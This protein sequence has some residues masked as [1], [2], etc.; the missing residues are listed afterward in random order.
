M[1]RFLV[2]EGNYQRMSNQQCSD[3]P[4]WKHTS[5]Y[6]YIFLMNTT[7]RPFWSIGSPV[8]DG[9]GSIVAWDDPTDSP[10]LVRGV[11]EEYDGDGWVMSPH[12]QVI[13]KGKYAISCFLRQYTDSG[14]IGG[15]LNLFVNKISYIII[16]FKF[17]L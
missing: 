15:L 7:T 8:C 11:W 6:Q 1:S 17:S 13:C 12:L 10:D 3:T 9:L 2:L 16:S 4:V 14:M 5:R